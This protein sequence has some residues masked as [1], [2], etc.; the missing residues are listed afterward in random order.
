MDYFIK[1]WPGV[2]EFGLTNIFT[3]TIL[4]RLRDNLNC[5]LWRSMD[6]DGSG[7]GSPYDEC[8]VSGTFKQQT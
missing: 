3:F 5:K 2:L 4:E 8:F 6:M 7:F 1:S